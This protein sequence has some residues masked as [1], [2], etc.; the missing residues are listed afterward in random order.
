LADEP[1][2]SLDGT[3]GAKVADLLLEEAKTQNAAVLLATHDMELAGRADRIVRLRD[4]IIQP[5]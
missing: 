3:A 1:T 5:D 2:G 4:G